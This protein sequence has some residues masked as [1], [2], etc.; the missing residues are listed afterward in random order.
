MPKGFLSNA[1]IEAKVSGPPLPSGAES[2]RDADAHQPA[3]VA[4][5]SQTSTSAGGAPGAQFGGPGQGG[6]P[7]AAA[8]ALSLWQFS[9][10]PIDTA[11]RLGLPVAAFFLWRGGH[12]V[13][14]GAAGAAAAV[15]WGNRLVGF[16][17]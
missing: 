14:A 12:H 11:L 6:A 3:S 17:L 10:Q 7:V 15:L 9:N 13:V 8:G 2:L 16:N 4:T 1:N 5:T